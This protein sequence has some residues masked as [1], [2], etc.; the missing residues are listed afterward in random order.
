MLIQ[1]LRLNFKKEEEEKVFLETENGM[2]IVLPKFL[3]EAHPDFKEGIFLSAD[4]KIMPSSDDY[5]KEMLNELVGN[6]KEE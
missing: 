4:T 1:N 3:L 5:K 6:N 2:E